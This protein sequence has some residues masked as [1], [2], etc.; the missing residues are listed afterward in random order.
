MGSAAKLSATAIG[1]LGATGFALAALLSLGA[2]VLRRKPPA[3]GSPQATQRPARQR[4]ASH[5]SA[6]LGGNFSVRNPA[7][8]P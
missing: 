6:Y 4:A 7:A 8:R 2:A 3:A 5:R 1:A